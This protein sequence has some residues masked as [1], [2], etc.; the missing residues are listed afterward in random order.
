MKN[1]VG[2]NVRKEYLPHHRLGDKQHGGDEY[3]KKS[4]F[5]QLSSKLLDIGNK[6]RTQGKK[7]TTKISLRLSG[8]FSK[9]DKKVFSKQEYR[10]GSWY[11]ND[12]IWRTIVDI[13]RIVKYADKSGKMQNMPQRNIFNI[14]DMIIIGEKEGPLLP[15]PKYGGVITM[16]EN[17]V[18]F[19]EIIASLLGMD[20]NK[21]P[22]Y[23]NVR[24]K[25]KWPIENDKDYGE[26]VSNKKEW[27]KKS[28]KEITR[29]IA[30]N[31]EPTSG[32][33]GNIEL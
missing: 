20:I 31:I 16:G 29:D 14:A 13:N 27:N 28:V 6:A 23:K 10:E 7:Y 25:R 4:M 21:I 26:I 22:L 15:T 9:L 1:F 19:D 17:I 24:A 32:W 2:A 33:K 3:N 5:L 11:G 8:I 30:I 18:C 12:T